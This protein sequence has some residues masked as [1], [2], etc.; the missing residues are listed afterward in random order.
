MSAGKIALEVVGE[1]VPLAIV[2]KQCG[3]HRDMVRR[4]AV[5]A[6]D[7]KNPD[8]VRNGH[9]SKAPIYIRES[10]VERL[11]REVWP[12]SSLAAAC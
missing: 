8:Y 11:K 3:V 1:W 7:R 2:A 4:L 12:V 10:E 9:S 6:I 5:E